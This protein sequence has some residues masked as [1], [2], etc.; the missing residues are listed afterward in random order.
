MFKPKLIHIV[1]MDQNRC[2]GNQGQLPWHLPSDLE[3]FQANTTGRTCIVGRKTYEG[4]P[5]KVQQDVKREF[6]VCS[7]DNG[8]DLTDVANFP[9]AHPNTSQEVLMIIGG[10]D[11]YQQTLHLAD[12]LLITQIKLEVDGDKFYPAF[13]DTFRLKDHSEWR[14]ENNIQ[15]RFTRWVRV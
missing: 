9:L 5:K 14:E 1:A 10:A 12:E 13:D 2:I 15:Y 6:I 3:W 8:N 7:R 11:V 4:L